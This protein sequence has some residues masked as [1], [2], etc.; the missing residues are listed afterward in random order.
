MKLFETIDGG[1]GEASKES[2][3]GT[4]TAVFGDVRGSH[5]YSSIYNGRTN[6]FASADGLANWLVISLKQPLGFLR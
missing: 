1:N 3:S 2:G 4:K 6:Q 5:D